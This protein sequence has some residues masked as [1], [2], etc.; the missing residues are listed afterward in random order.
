MGHIDIAG[1]CLARLC[2]MRVSQAYE[3]RREVK[4]S[5]YPKTRPVAIFDKVC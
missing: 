1:S 3:S 5:M 4:I 2:R